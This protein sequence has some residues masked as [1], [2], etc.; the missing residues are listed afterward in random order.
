MH[1]PWSRL[2]RTL[3]G[4]LPCEARTFLR[5][6]LSACR[7]RP[8]LLLTLAIVTYPRGKSNLHNFSTHTHSFL[9]LRRSPV[10]QY[11]IFRSIDLSHDPHRFHRHIPHGH[12]AGR[13]PLPSLTSGKICLLFPPISTIMAFALPPDGYFPVTAYHQN[14]LWR[15]LL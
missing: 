7:P 5:R 13:M 11:P 1:F 4:I 6:R 9:S 2:H 3:S 10:V 14:C 15:K 12:H 8:F